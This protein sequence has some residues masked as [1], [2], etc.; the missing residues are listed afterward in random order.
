[1]TGATTFP[2]RPNGVF[3]FSSRSLALNLRLIAIP[4]AIMTNINPSSSLVDIEDPGLVTNFR[5]QG[6]KFSLIFINVSNPKKILK[7]FYK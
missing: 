7:K 2:L 5:R 3:F 1:M 6:Q 4:M